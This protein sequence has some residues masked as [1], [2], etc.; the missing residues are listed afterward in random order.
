MNYDEY[1]KTFIEKYGQGK[2]TV[3]NYSSKGRTIFREVPSVPGIYFVVRS[4]SEQPIEF[5]FPGTGGFFKGND[6]N[7]SEEKLRT[8]WV[9]GSSIIYVGCTDNLNIRIDELLQFGQG[10]DVRHWGG[11]YMWQCK[12]SQ[13]FDVYWHKTID[14]E[15]AKELKA[16]L[17]RDFEVNH[18]KKPFAN[19]KK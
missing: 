17:I 3:G 13:T 11:R 14:K 16:S 7:V 9:N 8:K 12:D 6:P 5:I 15:A 19:L 18:D 1:T 2:V 4:D 10:E